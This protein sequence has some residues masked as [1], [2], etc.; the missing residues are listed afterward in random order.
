M[1]SIQVR[2]AN[3]HAESKSSDIK[4]TT[5]ED[6]QKRV[7]RAEDLFSHREILLRY[8]DRIESCQV[9]RVKFKIELKDTRARYGESDVET[10]LDTYQG[11][12][13]HRNERIT[14]LLSYVMKETLK[15]E[16]SHVEQELRELNVGFTG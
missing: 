3:A 15:I 5:F 11:R 12:Y 8:I 7:K 2:L 1:K 16:L 4:I 10:V 9:E 13:V 14:D 6:L